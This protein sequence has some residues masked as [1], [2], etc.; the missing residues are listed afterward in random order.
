MLY[1]LSLPRIIPNMTD[2]RIETLYME[3]GQQIPGGKLLDLSID[4]G[5]GV[6]QNCPP[7]SYY[8]LVSREKA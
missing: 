7:I 8:R 5:D 3:I 6:S 2:A 4:L 1:E